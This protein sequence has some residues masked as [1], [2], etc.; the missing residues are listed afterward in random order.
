LAVFK[1]SEAKLFESSHPG[2]ELVDTF[3]LARR[4]RLATGQMQG[5]AGREC[6]EQKNGELST[7]RQPP[8]AEKRLAANRAATITG[9]QHRCS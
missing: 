5:D 4:R 1:V 6:Q 7:H 3:R 8:R 2:Y 9:S